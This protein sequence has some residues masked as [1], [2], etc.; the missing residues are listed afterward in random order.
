MVNHA[1]I[2]KEIRKTVL[3]MIYRAQ[4][5][6]VGSNFSAID[7]LT[8]LYSKANFKKDKLIVSKGWIAASIY[9]FGVKYGLCPQEAIDTFCD[10]KSKYIGLIEP[11]GFFGAEFA[12]GSMG[13]GLSAAVGYALSKK[14]KGEEGTIFVLM[15]DGEMQCGTTWESALI[16]KQYKLSNLFVIVDFNYLQAMGKVEDILDIEPLR[17]KFSDF[18]WDA[19]ETNGHD[20]E[21]LENAIDQSQQ[22]A[23][24]NPRIMIAR[25]TK[26]KGVSFIENNNL[27]HYAKLTE[28]DY[29]K[30]LKELSKI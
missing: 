27:Y 19:F 8:V 11:L 4:V 17:Y 12:G 14:L 7:I 21:L 16:A 29:Q 13:L 5:S 22:Y 20:Y 23:T 18:G 28:E 15:S 24:E 30:A 2:A 9:A 3:S 10:G 26:G 1:E 6:H 25:T